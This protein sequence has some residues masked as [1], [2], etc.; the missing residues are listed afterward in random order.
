[1]ACLSPMFSYQNLVEVY[2]EGELVFRDNQLLSNTPFHSL[3]HAM[4]GYQ[5]RH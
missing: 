3:Q 4:K 2:V 5:V 1:M